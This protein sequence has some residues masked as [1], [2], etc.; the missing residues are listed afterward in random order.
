VAGLKRDPHDQH[1]CSFFQSTKILW[2]FDIGA[3]S[4]RRKERIVFMEI[5]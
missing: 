5:L 2:L 4:R 1:H 3:I